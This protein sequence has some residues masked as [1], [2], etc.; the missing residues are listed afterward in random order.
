MRG[1][2]SPAFRL[3]CCCRWAAAWRKFSKRSSRR[4]SSKIGRRYRVFLFAHPFERQR[5][6]LHR[7]R[8]Q[9]PGELYEGVQHGHRGGQAGRHPKRSQHGHSAHRPPRYPRLYRLQEEQRGNH[10]LQYLGGHSPRRL[11]RRWSKAALLPDHPKDGS[12]VGQ[13]DRRGL[14][15]NVESAGAT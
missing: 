12:V 4:A 15:Q 7:R 10:Q 5:G 11:C 14:P 2:R 8:G 3:L 6:A 1:G 13:L 9:R